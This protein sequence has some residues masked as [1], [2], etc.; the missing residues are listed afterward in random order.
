VSR[1]ADPTRFSIGAVFPWLI[2]L[3]AATMAAG[4][5]SG[6]LGSLADDRQHG[7]LVLAAWLGLIVYANI[8]AASATAP[9][10]VVIGQLTKFLYCR[11]GLRVNA[12][13]H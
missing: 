4:P 11:P 9:S 1:H 2:M 3:A 10:G 5:S 7:T 6:L 8:A 12:H 13:G